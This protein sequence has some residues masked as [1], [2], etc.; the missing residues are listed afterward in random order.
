MKCIT[1]NK[2]FEHTGMSKPG[3]K[4]EI[5]YVKKN[6]DLRSTNIDITKL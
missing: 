1:I 3:N 5:F 2:Y 6:S 4:S